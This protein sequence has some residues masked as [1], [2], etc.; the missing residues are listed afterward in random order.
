M[1]IALGRNNSVTRTDYAWVPIGGGER[2]SMGAWRR[3]GKAIGARM[4]FIVPLCVTAGVLF[5]GVFG[6]LSLIH[7]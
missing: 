3:L 4:P 5:P 2:S 7:I 6:P 1:R